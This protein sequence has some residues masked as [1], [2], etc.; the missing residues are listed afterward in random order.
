MRGEIWEFVEPEREAPW[1][2]LVVQSDALERR[3]P[4]VVGLVVTPRAQAAGE[5]LALALEPHESG[6]DGPA[7]VKVTQVRTLAVADARMQLGEVEPRRM[8]EVDRALALVLG[9][10]WPSTRHP[11]RPGT[12]AARMAG[13]RDEVASEEQPRRPG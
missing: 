9:F 10:D 4:T 5:P 2:L 1:N 11:G 13:G 3:A 8:A 7:W 12:P 6:L